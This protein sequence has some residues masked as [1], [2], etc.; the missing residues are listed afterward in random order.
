MCKNNPTDDEHSEGKTKLHNSLWISHDIIE[1][2]S[3]FY[4][5]TLHYQLFKSLPG[6][7]NLNVKHKIDGIFNENFNFSPSNAVNAKDYD[8]TLDCRL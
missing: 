7:E 3:N 6:F 4:Y 2:I 5:S 1:N 8:K